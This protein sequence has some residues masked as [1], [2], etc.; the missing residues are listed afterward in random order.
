MANKMVYINLP[1]KDLDLSKTLYEALG[2]VCNPHMSDET[3]ACMAWSDHIYVMLLTHAKWKSFTTRPI[4]ESGS[5]EAAFALSCES[6]DAVREMVAAAAA[7]GGTPDINPPE[8]HGFMLQ[9]SFTDLDGHVWE[10]F[11]MDPAAV[12]PSE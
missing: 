12:P 3:A 8:D 5:S 6:K 2:L 4:P 9:R 10:P 7:A 1:V 11:W